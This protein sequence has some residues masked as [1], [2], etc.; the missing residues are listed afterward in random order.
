[1]SKCPPYLVSWVEI[2]V[3]IEVRSLPLDILDEVTHCAIKA[4]AS[5]TFCTAKARRS[6]SFERY[7]GGQYLPSDAPVAP[8]E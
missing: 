2:P 4:Y 6:V 8:V 7:H 5:C 3:D 1:M